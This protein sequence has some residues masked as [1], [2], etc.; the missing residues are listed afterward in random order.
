MVLQNITVTKICIKF[1]FGN[2]KIQ[3][4]VWYIVLQ[5]NETF[6]VGFG[7]EPGADWGEGLAGEHQGDP[8][9]GQVD[10]RG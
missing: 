9:G 8:H 10:H 1:K 6:D 7:Q 3:S 2:F 5:N 4:A